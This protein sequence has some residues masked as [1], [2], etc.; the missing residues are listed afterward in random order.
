MLYK[1]LIL[2]VGAGR[3]ERPTPCAQGRCATRL[4]YAPT[5]EAFLILK[6]F[7]TAH[8]LHRTLDASELLPLASLR[9]DVRFNSC[10]NTDARVLLP[11][12]SKTILPPTIVIV[13]CVFPMSA[14][15][16][17]KISRERTAKS[18]NLPGSIVPVSFSA[19]FA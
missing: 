8:L 11:Y 13:T 10:L 19:K 15:W 3:F 17:E 6:H 4:R 7:L 16:A 2:L 1:S 18:A 5:S 9:F 12:R 14:G